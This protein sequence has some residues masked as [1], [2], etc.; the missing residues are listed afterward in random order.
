VKAWIPTRREA[1]GLVLAAGLAGLAFALHRLIG[2]RTPYVSDVILAIALGALVLNTPLR[3][4]LGL[5]APTSRDADPYERGLRFTGKWVLRLAIILMGLKIQ[6]HL[7]RADQLVVVLAVLCFSVPTAF[8]LAHFA[9]GR[10][11]LRREMGDLLGIGTM[12]CGASAINALSPVIFA[13]RR[14]Q[15]LA[16][17]AVFLFSV[18]ALV[19]FYPLGQALGLSGED[20]GLWSG[21]AVNDLSGSVA[22]GSQFGEEAGLIATASKSVRIVLLGPLLVLF[23][24]LRPTAREAGDESLASKLGKHLPLFILGY[25]GMFGVRLGGDTLWADQD[26]WATVLAT[27]HHVVRLLIL[28]VCAGIG[29]QIEVATLV[30]VGWKAVVAGAAASVGMAGLT[31]LMLLAFAEDAPGLAVAAGA[32]ALA[33]AYGLYRLG[34]AVGSERDGLLRRLASGAPLSMREAAD[35]LAIHDEDEALTPEVAAGILGN[36]HPAIGELQPLRQSAIVGDINYR[37]LVYWKSP[38]GA[39]SLVGILWT[40]GTRGHIHSHDYRGVGRRVEGHVE[41]LDFA[42]AGA[43]RLRVT[44]RASVEPG[45]LMSIE[46]VD[47]IHVVTNRSTCDAIDVHFY[48]PALAGAAERFLC[49]RDVVELAAGDEIAV[50]S[51][52]DRL[53]E[54]PV[55]TGAWRGGSGGLRQ[56]RFRL[57]ED[58]P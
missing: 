56:A 52:A 9:A 20:F 12:V 28:A 3:V 41:V 10:L 21:L 5:G 16:I 29:L 27:N 45:A 39:G 23:S 14:D 22:V 42:R 53:P 48:G 37:R 49:D 51:A 55:P 44:G 31:L 6:T 34:Q 47:T 13:R 25:F 1:P 26:A 38:R 57:R 11:G 19:A 4:V 54:V 7:F 35:L 46:G 40:P 24:L 30:E 58:P 32:I 43:E 36:L 50:R 15:G 2:A 17:T 18:G 8:L 33:F